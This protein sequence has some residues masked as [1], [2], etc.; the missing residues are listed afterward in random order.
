M[1]GD[2]GMLYIAICD[3]NW[4]VCSEIENILLQYKK[5]TG[6]LLEVEVFYSGESF[7][8]YQKQGK[9]FDLLYLDIEMEQ[10]NGLEVGHQ[11]RNVWKNYVMEIVYISGK[12]GY[13]RQLFAYQPLHFLTKPFSKKQII[14]VLELAVIRA[15]KNQEYYEYKKKSNI[16]RIPLNEILYFE[17][18]KREIK[19]VTDKGIDTFYASLDEIEANLALKQFVRIHRSYFVNYNRISVVR[20]AEVEMSNQDILPISKSKQQEF[21]K[22]QINEKIW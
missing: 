3:N 1:V 6:F 4:Q 16:Y 14:D 8:Q 13:D 9:I 11:V 21:R 7:L 2:R 18:I 12:E 15:K 5:E 17:S 10:G 22:Y 20:Y 19:I